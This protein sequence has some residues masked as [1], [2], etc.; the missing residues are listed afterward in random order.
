[1]ATTSPLATVPKTP[2][3][4]DG[5]FLYTPG[6]DLYGCLIDLDY[7][8]VIA[9][10]DTSGIPER[11]GTYPFIAIAILKGAA[12]HRYRHDLESFLYVLLWVAC[13]PV[14]S[15]QSSIQAAPSGDARQGDIWPREDPLNAWSSQSEA[16][17]ATLKSS[18][19]VMYE[20]VFE[21]LLERFRPGF[22]R[23][24]SAA[25]DMRLALWELYDTG[26]CIV[27]LEGAGTQE[28][29][30]RVGHR[31]RRKQLTALGAGD[32]RL[33]VSNWKGFCDFRG[34][35]EELVQWLESEATGD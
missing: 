21:T 4:I 13:Y 1:M 15:T 6:T 26:K 24:K 3:T 18:N 5:E 14:A 29:T 25:R 11:T 10:Q 33:G 23:F 16:S 8:V 31:R 35:L 2:P 7:A 30:A 27:E 19:I 28:G 12:T 34:I 9:E 32:V 22:D 17:V 20:D